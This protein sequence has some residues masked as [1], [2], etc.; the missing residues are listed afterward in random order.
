MTKP[1][2][3]V[4]GVI[5]GVLVGLAVLWL[6]VAPDNVSRAEMVSYVEATAIE[7]L[8]LLREDIRNVDESLDE[9]AQR[10]AAVEAVLSRER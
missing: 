8:R 2:E 3:I 5:V 9:V 6:T 4:A 1:G 10:L 7:H